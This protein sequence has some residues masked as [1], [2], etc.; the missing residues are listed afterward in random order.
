MVE[1]ELEEFRKTL[2]S[3]LAS[4]LGRVVLDMSAVPFVDSVGLETLLDVS[5]E[6]TRVGRCLKLCGLNKTLRR[7][8]DL[9]EIDGHFDLYEEANSAVRSFL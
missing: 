6:L 1:A 7:V 8:L 2:N 3:L 9:T 4:T 5:D